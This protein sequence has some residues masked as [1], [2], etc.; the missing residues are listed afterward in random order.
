MGLIDTYHIATMGQNF[1]QTYTLASNGILIKIFIE[2]VVPGVGGDSGGYIHGGLARNKRRDHEERNRQDYR[3]RDEHKKELEKG[4]E[5]KKDKPDILKQVTV[6]ATINGEEHIKTKLV[7]DR[8][9]L[10]VSDVKVEISNRDT[11]PKI[12]ITILS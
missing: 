3:H 11:K 4:K 10:K 2:D 6:V 7:E 9:D 5:K 1:T 12:T 8:P